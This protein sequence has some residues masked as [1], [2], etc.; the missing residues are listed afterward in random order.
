[1]PVSGTIEEAA[2]LLTREV[3]ASAARRLPGSTLGNLVRKH[4]PGLLKPTA[5]LSLTRLL[6]QH[7]P[8]LTVVARAGHD[9]VW[10]L[11]RPDDAPAVDLDSL[12]LVE[13][14]LLEM[15]GRKPKDVS[16]QS[17]RLI[18]YRSIRDLEL[19]LEPLTVLVGPNG[20][21]K[22]NIL[23]GIFRGVQLTHQ[24]PETVFDGPHAFHRVVRRGA[25]GGLTVVLNGN[26]NWSMKFTSRGAG[27][28]PSINARA[29]GESRQLPS[30]LFTPLAQAFGPVVRLNLTAS[31]L[32]RPT[33]SEEEDPYLRRDGL[34]LASVLD[35]L[36]GNDRTRLGE[37]IELVQQLVPQVEDL[38]TPRRRIEV[39][40][41]EVI[42]IDEQ[43]VRRPVVRPRM[44]NSLEVKIRGSGWTPADQLSEGTL[45]LLGLHTMLSR[46]VKPKI[47]LIDDLDRAL[48]PNAQRKLVEQ[49]QKIVA[50]GQRIVATSH[51]PFVLDPLPPEAVRAIQID[52]HGH[53]CMQPMTAHHELPA[54]RDHMTAAEFW[55]YAGDDWVAAS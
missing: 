26:D 29:G 21:G 41:W 12:L 44:G 55:Q 28:S 34:F 52:D 2:E 7:A 10:G 45:L 14:P 38:R 33:W 15:R 48:H 35:H 9:L 5:G 19:V 39:R 17:V 11:D 24:K 16:L 23:D 18:D 22:S 13:E 6:D 40:E 43:E 42:R 31:M 47:I 37:I 25:T 50:P 20:A 46:S 3:E 36:G 30:V 53:T 54:W 27:G 8:H 51:S 1:M 4:F 49:L 32:S